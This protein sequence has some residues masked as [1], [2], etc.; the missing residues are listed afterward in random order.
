MKGAQLALAVQLRDTASF[1]SYF[2]GPNL[3]V[4]TALRELA[5]PLALFGPKGSGRT[6]LLQAACREHRG[7]YLPLA[8]IAGENP[9]LLAGFERARAVFIDDVDAVAA[10]RDWCLALLRLLDALRSAGRPH[11]LAMNAAPERLL[12]ALPDLRTRL[13]QCALFGL[14]PL[15]D[16]ERAALLRLRARH[17]GLDLPDEVTRWLLNTRSR[18]TGSLLDA[19]DALDRAALS[20]KRRLTL[21]LAQSVLGPADARTTPG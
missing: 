10:R 3:D 7:A 1:D 9:E 16:D 13:N 14:K 4:V 8:A 17:R 5:Q 15:D 6:H 2:A 12:L 18:D 19:L 20:A 11:A 21:A